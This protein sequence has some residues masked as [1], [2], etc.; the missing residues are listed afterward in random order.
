MTYSNIYSDKQ[1][2]TKLPTWKTAVGR[3]LWPRPTDRRITSDE[4]EHSIHSTRASVETNWRTAGRRFSGEGRRAGGA[5]GRQA[6]A[7]EDERALPSS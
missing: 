1:I 4:N 6:A 3:R 5:G 2:L 7:Q